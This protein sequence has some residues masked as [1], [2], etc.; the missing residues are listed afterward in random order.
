MLE[1]VYQIR[2]RYKNCLVIRIPT[3]NIE[4]IHQVY[5]D[6]ARQ[7]KIT[8]SNE[9]KAD[10]KKLIQG[11][12]SRESAGR[13]LLVFNNTDNINIW[14]THSGPGSGRLIGVLPRSEQR[15]IIFTTRD[16][17]TGDMTIYRIP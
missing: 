9:D 10:I 6:V 12:L 8:G 7:L 3:T 4:S 5:L 14:I 17:K 11:Y 13:W 2:D 15:Y 1:L 16:R